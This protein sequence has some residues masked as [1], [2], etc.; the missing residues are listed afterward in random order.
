MKNK[1]KEKVENKEVDESK[2]SS[3]ENKE[4]KKETLE[5]RV[6]RLEAESNHWKNEY[7]RVFADMKNLRNSLEKERLENLKYRSEGFIEELL[8]ILDSFHVALS[9]EPN[10]PVLKNYLVGFQYVY[11]NLISVLENEGVSE[12]NPKIGDVFNANTMNAVEAVEDD[13]EENRVIQVFAR[14]Y[15]LHDRMVRHAMVKV[16]V[17]PQPKKEEAKEEDNKE[18]HA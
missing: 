15:K 16:S 10:D 1:D 4:S 18:I 14:G 11:R 2:E 3:S 7:F 13:G 17:K 9:N 5:E 6:T 8:P 12:I